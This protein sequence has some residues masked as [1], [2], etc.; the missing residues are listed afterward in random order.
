MNDKGE[1]EDK[2]C[3]KLHSVS[4]GSWKFMNIEIWNGCSTMVKYSNFS[5]H[6]N[7]K[8]IFL[9]DCHNSDEIN[10]YE[11]PLGYKKEHIRFFKLKQ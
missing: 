5:G 1:S 11:I 6:F 4:S 10:Y 7:I 2:G 3:R 9:C 8:W